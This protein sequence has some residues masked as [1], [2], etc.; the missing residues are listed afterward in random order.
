MEHTVY[1]LYSIIKNKYYI[2]YTAN[3]EEK[4]VRHNQKPKGFTGS[5]ND[6]QLVYS[7]KYESKSEALMRE[8]QI[9]NWK[10]RTKIEELVK[11][12]NL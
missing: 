8:K 2:G 1:I 4:I 7:E 5:T 3:I 6:W 9:K 12:F 11:S 10:S